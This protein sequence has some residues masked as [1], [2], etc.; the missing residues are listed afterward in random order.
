MT[1]LVREKAQTQKL[2]KVSLL[3]EILCLKIMIM[4]LELRG[5]LPS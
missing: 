5:T 3:K 4:N 2:K 1:I